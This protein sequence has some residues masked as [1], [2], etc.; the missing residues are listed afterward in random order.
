MT[1]SRTLYGAT[2]YRLRLVVP[3]HSVLVKRLEIGPAGITHLISAFFARSELPHELG[4]GYLFLL[5]LSSFP[6]NQ[7]SMPCHTTVPFGSVP[8]S[9]CR[10]NTEWELYCSGVAGAVTVHSSR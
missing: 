9:T 8:I 2:T 1:D 10:E 4:P 5:A 7:F 3:N 6:A